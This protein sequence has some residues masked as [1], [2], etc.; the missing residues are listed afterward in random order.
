VWSGETQGF[1]KELFD[2][3]NN[4]LHKAVDGLDAETEKL[5][6]NNITRMAASK[7]QYT[8]MLLEREKAAS[9]SYEQYKKGASI[10]IG[11]ANTAQTAEYNTAVHRTR[12][13]KQWRQF[14]KESNLYPNIEWIRTRSATPRELHLEYAGHVWAK[15]DPFWN[16]NQPGC[17]WNCKC[18]WK[19]TD[20]AVTQGSAGDVKPSPG[21]EGNP[22]K[23]NE[24]FTAKHPY[25]SRVDNH[26]PELGVLHNPDD[27]AYLNQV[28]A[29]KTYKVHFNAEKAAETAENKETV[30]LL[31]QNGFDDIA[32]L[33]TIH[34]SE[35]ALRSRYFGAA[36]NSR[37]PA[38]NPDAVVDGV[39]TEFKQSKKRNLA[40]RITQAA[41]KSEMAI[42]RLTEDVD[43]KEIAGIVKRAW[44]KESNENL[45]TIVIIINKE[46]TRFTRP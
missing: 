15:D 6:K 35:T 30:R 29:G 31:L 5:L 2:I 20:R 46:V 38:A 9:K 21:L 13:V 10:V 28:A 12:V 45:K 32:L 18:S 7:A 34:K 17:I 42:I 37:F 40:H 19:S 3:Y 36:F 41:A 11:R 44:T 4:D 22:A 43:S 8:T 24:I 26:I 14:E 27:I 16:Q 25:F 33:P 23:T 1:N 39:I